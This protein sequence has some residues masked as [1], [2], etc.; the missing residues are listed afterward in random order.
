VSTEKVGVP[1]GAGSPYD[2]ISYGYDNG[3]RVTSISDGLQGTVTNQ[4]DLLNDLTSQATAQGTLGYTYNNDGDR[5]TT[6]A[7]G[8]PATNYSY[9]N[10][11]NLKTIT[12]ST[13]SV[14][15]TYNADNETTAL[16]LPN[17]DVE[18][19]TPDADGQVTA[20]T[21]TNGSKSLG[22]LAY[23]YDAN[24][25]EIS[26]SGNSSDAS[27]PAAVSPSTYN[28]DNQATTFNGANLTYDNDGHLTSD[29][30]TGQSY[31]W[32]QLDELTSIAG[33]STP[34]SFTYD[35]T[36]RRTTATFNGTSNSYL[37]DGESLIGDSQGS[38]TTSYLTDGGGGATYQVSS[39]SGS[40]S[41]ITDP[42]GSTVALGNGSGAISTKYAYSPSGVTT[43]AGTS[44]P[45]I[46]EALGQQ[47]DPT[48][49]DY[50]AAGG[51]YS[52]LLQQSLSGRPLKS[53]LK[54]WSGG[55]SGGSGSWSCTNCAP[56]TAD[57]KAQG[58]V[59]PDNYDGTVVF[60]GPDGGPIPDDPGG[61]DESTPPSGTPD[62][63]PQDC[64][65]GLICSSPGFG[66]TN[67][68]PDIQPLTEIHGLIDD[69]PVAQSSS[70]S[71]TSTSTPPG[72]VAGG[73]AVVATGGLIGPVSVSGTTQPP[74]PWT[75]SNPPISIQLTPQPTFGSGKILG[76]LVNVPINAYNAVVNFQNGNYQASAESAANAL[77]FG[78]ALQAAQAALQIGIQIGD[79]FPQ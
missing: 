6:T 64:P 2:T 55:G 73:D 67:F 58:P 33:G 68:A 56:D 5:L 63:T 22:K 72:F 46:I 42:I 4:Y 24:G 23:K 60:L 75:V 70:T 25:N 26:I 30:S 8:L 28:A 18:N 74:P 69:T 20:E 61:G 29:S 44:S 12:Q 43:T 45:N 34:A 17:G 10:D 47:A 21:V 3:D 49:L 31:T 14:G 9:D 59:D 50:S 71:S 65:A 36:G 19:F 13:S 40:S 54:S 32:N 15:F 7:P 62:W 76:T 27:L 38:A 37:Y 79:P 53:W 48:G 51:Y 1:S 11:N 41:L 66:V 39:S 16:S 35:P 78:K 57:P 77:G 52:P